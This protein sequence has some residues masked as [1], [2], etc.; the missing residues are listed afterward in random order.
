ML[1]KI[2]ALVINMKLGKKKIS[3]RAN[4]NTKT[5]PVSPLQYAGI[6]SHLERKYPHSEIYV[7]KIT[8]A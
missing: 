4:I 2:E 6:K 3:F 8:E 1:I 7:S 5:L